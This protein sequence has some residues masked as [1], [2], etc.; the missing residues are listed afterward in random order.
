MRDQSQNA[1]PGSN[2]SMW[3]ILD[4]ANVYH[5]AATTLFAKAQKKKPLSYAPARLCCIHA[6]ELYL[7]V[8]LR[9]EGVLP[10]HIR[11]RMHNLADSAFVAQLKLRKKTARHLESMTE[12][13]EYLIS[14]YG[15]EQIAEHSE[16][17]RLL[18]TLVEIAAKLGQYLN[19]EGLSRAENQL[20][21]Q[22]SM[23]ASSA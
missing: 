19:S 21:Q 1:Y 18:A 22:T 13:R 17:N 6:I 16:L 9:H 5:A 10:E 23:P 11:A 12:K 2:A 15:P 14:R 8:F 3:Q 20:Q 4:L 7:N